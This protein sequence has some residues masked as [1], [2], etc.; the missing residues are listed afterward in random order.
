MGLGVL[1][2]SCSQGCAGPCRAG[3]AVLAG[4]GRA[5]TRGTG[6]TTPTRGLS[7]S[8][9][10]GTYKK[11]RVLL[12]WLSCGYYNAG[13]DLAATLSQHT[14]LSRDAVAAYMTVV[15]VEG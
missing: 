12:A 14:G 3:R 13:P 9:R 5:A 6:G 8:G 10:Q 11:E 2:P 7:I 4:R 1:R 15:A